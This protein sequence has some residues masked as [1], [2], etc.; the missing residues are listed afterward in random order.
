MTASRTAP[1]WG[2]RTRR[3][4]R[5]GPRVGAGRELRCAG[6]PRRPA[7]TVPPIT[8]CGSRVEDATTVLPAVCCRRADTLRLRRRR[9]PEEEVRSARG[10]GPAGAHHAPGRRASRIRIAD[11]HH[12]RGPLPDGANGRP[13]HSSC[14][15]STPLGQPKQHLGHGRPPRLP[16][17]PMTTSRTVSRPVS[18]PKRATGTSR[19][20]TA[21][22]GNGP[23]GSRRTPD[24]GSPG[25]R[26]AARSGPPATPTAS[27]DRSGRG[28]RIPRW[29]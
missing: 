27:P 23:T 1:T 25:G 29:C 28:R 3:C 24:P 19:A 18:A 21:G 14:R 12:A 8:R 4:S 7:H 9:Q 16:T 20:V 6:L 13:R 5:E 22:S 11:S 10:A 15:T 26:S 17:R 2:P